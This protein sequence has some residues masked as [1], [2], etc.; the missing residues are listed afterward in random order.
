MDADPG[1]PALAPI[2]GPTVGA[3]TPADPIAGDSQL[4]TVA[5]PLPSKQ[6][7]G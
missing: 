6:L 5:E 3:A 7:N 1:G 2:A 4:V